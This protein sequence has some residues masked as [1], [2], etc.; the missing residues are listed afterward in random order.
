MNTITSPFAT[1][2]IVPRHYWVECVAK[3][4]G[5]LF[6]AE[7]ECGWNFEQTSATIKTVSLQNTGLPFKTEKQYRKL[8]TVT[9]VLKL[10]T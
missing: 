6:H 4:R 8:E 7:I 5:N 2:T 10:K 9:L 3:D 1:E